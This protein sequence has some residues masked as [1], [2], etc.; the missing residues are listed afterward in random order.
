MVK[1]DL[2]HQVLVHSLKIPKGDGPS[3]IKGGIWSPSLGL[4]DNYLIEGP[5]QYFFIRKN[6]E[7]QSKV[8]VTEKVINKLQEEFGVLSKGLFI[9]T[10]GGHFKDGKK[11]I[12]SIGRTNK[13]D[14]NEFPVFPQFAS[15]AFL[16]QDTVEI[17]IL[18]IEYPKE[19]IETDYKYVGQAEIPNYFFK[20][21]WLVYNFVSF[22]ELFFYN[23]KTHEKRK[24][25]LNTTYELED[26]A[27]PF[28]EKPNESVI[29]YGFPLVDFEQEI[30]Y[31]YYI[32]VDS[33]S[34]TES[35]NYLSAYNFDGKLISEAFLGKNSERMLRNSVL[36]GDYIYMNNFFQSS[37]ERI[38]FSRFSLQKK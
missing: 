12:V 33:E 25:R 6:G 18:D 23:L 19:L 17:E 2:D 30:I 37:D 13:I 9:R 35:K 21:D 28:G 8:D 15:I 22:R 27:V 31:R 10:N 4:D 14:D 26:K 11:I 20:G 32:V 38:E 34:S 7:I 1:L 24:I 3:G 36:I 16:N 29:F 5:F